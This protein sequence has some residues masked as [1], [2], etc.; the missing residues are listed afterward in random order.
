MSLYSQ[1]EVLTRTL[2][3]RH[4]QM[5]SIGGIIGAG[6]FMGSGAAIAAI[7]PAVIISYLIAGLVILFVMRMMSE[8]ASAN[9]GVSA[10]TEY[11][12]LGLGHWAGF[13]SGWLY[14]YFWVIVVAVEAIVGAGIISQWIHL[15]VWQ[16]G[17]ALMLLL[18]GVNLMSARSYGEFEYWFSSI[19]IAAILSFIVVGTASLLGLHRTGVGLPNL[20]SHGGFAPNGLVSVVSGVTTVIFALCGAEIATIA[21]VESRESMRVISRLTFTTVILVLFLYV[22]SVLII[23]AIVPWNEVQ[24]GVSPFATALE[25]LA[26]PGASTLMNIAV[27][28]AVLS[29]MNSGVYVSSRV[30][31]VLAAHDDAPKWVIKLSPRRRVPSRAIL[32]GSAFG[33]IAVIASVI[34]PTLLF[35]FLVNASG[36]L[37]LMIYLLVAFA[38]LRMRHELEAIDPR[39]LTVRMWGFPWLTWL[40]IAAITASLLSMLS[41]RSTANEL[42]SS[43]ISLAVV[44]VACAIRMLGMA[45]RKLSAPR[46]LAQRAHV[47]SAEGSGRR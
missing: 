24:P 20:I 16:I 3:S 34:S 43:V 14:W 46:P 23:V 47:P 11:T 1:R 41:Q 10:F 37:M 32:I 26:I 4:I 38:Q 5:I 33:Y 40:V 30:L 22:L 28:T 42:Y 9:V 31:F 25:R 44:A 6:L 15:P 13:I 19:K 8:M 18:T 2:L 12:R 29:C 17:L 36:A 21:A 27:L 45:R 35:A 39:R 7:G